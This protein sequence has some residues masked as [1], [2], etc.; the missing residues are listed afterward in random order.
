MS[1]FSAE[2]SVLGSVLLKP[3]AFTEASMLLDAA[4]FEHPFNRAVF[5][6]MTA[7]VSRGVPV[8]V[9]TLDDELRT[10]GYSQ[11][12]EGG[13]LTYLSGLAGEVVHGESLKHHAGIVARRSALRRL[14]FACTQIADVADASPDEAQRLMLDAQKLL[15]EVAKGRTRP[16]VDLADV[17][18][19]VLADI[20]KRRAELA[21]GRGMVSGLSTGL[22]ALDFKTSGFA[23]GTLN[24]VAARTSLGKT[25]YACQVALL[26][27][28]CNPEPV[29]CLFFSL[30]MRP[31]E[32]G[33]RFFARLAKVASDKIRTGD[34]TDSQMDRLRNASAQM[35][36][37]GLITISN[38]R[39][40]AG[41][42]TE[43][44]AFRVQHPERPILI[45]VDYLQLV[46]S[47]ER[48]RSREQE[49]AAVSSALKELSVEVNA[50]V[51]APAQFNR[52]PESEDRAPTIAD[53]RESGAI[54]NDADV[55]LMIHRRRENT[56][57][58]CHII[59]GKS[60]NG[61][62]GEVD[63]IW[64]GP[65]YELRDVESEDMRGF[66]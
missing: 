1:E 23:P 28:L 63:A 37:R 36:Q 64:N 9:L 38:T 51:V 6:A 54:E 8:D 14:K 40:L 48:G 21:A 25:A 33:R 61:D 39:S 12:M 34:L 42:F 62:L 43:S 55:I 11:R 13:P 56:S 50:P 49:V 19:D 57:G 3:V 46:R 26:G 65:T 52:A 4:D 60:R 18:P 45:V 10:A 20:E 47:G 16:G 24:I 66:Q 41:I 58:L 44:R 32:L 31:V 30:E 15:V 2:R 53:I 22:T 59:I 7:L 17:A 29:P 5:E 35:E 27:A